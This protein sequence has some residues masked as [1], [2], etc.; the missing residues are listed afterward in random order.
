MNWLWYFLALVP[1]ARFLPLRRSSLPRTARG[2]LAG[3]ILTGSAVALAIGRFVDSPPTVEGLLVALLAA[4]L[5]VLVL[6]LRH[7]ASDRAEAHRLRGIAQRNAD[8]ISVV[9]HEIRTP[10]SLMKGAADLL[11]EASP[12]PLTDSQSRF[13][14]TI[15][16][17][18]HSVIT[19]SEDLLTQARIDAGMFELH[20]QRVNLR[21]LTMSVISELRH[22]HPL[23]IA[24]DCPG[25]PPRLWA[26]PMLV[27]QALTNLINNAVAHAR[28]AELITVRVVNADAQILV[29]VSDDGE[30]IPEG[31]RQ[32]LF[33][34]FRSGKPLRDG[35]GLGLVITRAIIQ[36]HGGDVFVDSTP[37]RGT[38]MLFTLPKDG[39]RSIESEQG[40]AR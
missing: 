25:A 12:G 28:N 14:Q 20:P 8:Q 2:W 15:S 7:W 39:S 16:A 38:T 23:P 21:A 3:L 32:R 37:N 30:G 13:V 31:E 36:M 40:V 5:A 22:L 10:L 6:V 24:L 9:S 11:A 35:T 17:N 4:A 33:E 26:D 34:R 1:L 19:L 29:S 18:C 27:R